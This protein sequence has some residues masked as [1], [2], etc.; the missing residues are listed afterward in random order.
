M[1]SD[2]I[3]MW[4]A[5][6]AWE[7]FSS[8]VYNYRQSLKASMSHKKHSFQKN[9]IFSAVTTVEA[10]T[11]ELLAKEKGW[12]ERQIN[13]C[14]DKLGEFGIDYKN[15]AFKDSKFVRNQFIVHHKRNDYRYFIEIN[16]SSA[17]DAI[18]SVQSIIAE[19]SYS[20]KVIFPYWITGLNFRNPAHGNDIFLINDY[21]FWSR[22]KWAKL[23]ERLSS[24]ATATGDLTVPREKDTY[25]NLY[26]EIWKLLKHTN[27]DLPAIEIEDTRFP[28]MPVLTS[29]WW[30]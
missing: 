14:K 17:L 11:N 23:N 10:Y 1:S 12:T 15:S 7:L 27:F 29:K 9:V 16:E 30:E 20:R 24:V 21:E 5:N 28:L 25:L 3:W 4:N 22:I 18:E 13:D 8:A 26:E 6:L 19:I 2:K